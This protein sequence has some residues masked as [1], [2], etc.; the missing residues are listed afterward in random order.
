MFL[1]GPPSFRQSLGVRFLGSIF[2]LVLAASSAAAAPS[3][4][5]AF[6]GIAMNDFGGGCLITSTTR[7]S[8]AED[9]GIRID[10]IVVAMDG[11]PLADITKAP[12][13]RRSACD[14][15]RDR[16]MAHTPGDIASFEVRRGGKALTIKLPLSTRADVQHRCFVGQSVPNIETLDID[17]PKREVE[18]SEFHGKTTVLAWFRLSRCVGC[19]SVIDKVDERIHE[20]IKDA[21]PS[22]VGITTDGFDS[23]LQVAPPG[24]PGSRRAN[25]TFPKRSTFAST[26]PLLVAA[27]D[28][29]KEMTLQ[30]SDRVQ[31]MVVDCRG[32]IRFVSLLAAG[33]DDL[34]AA[35]DEVLAAVEQAEYQRTRR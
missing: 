14:V 1:A 28:D 27:E 18:L 23:Q 20:R 9:A 15:L 29:F 25:P 33:S 8:P 6:L 11:E 24:A 16:I 12:P 7:C 5:P 34:E 19:A 3:S 10:D 2:V 4:N 32:V 31:M 22:V 26:L 13:A 17:N 35:I 30:E 21:A